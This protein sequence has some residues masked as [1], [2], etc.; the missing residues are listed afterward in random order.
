MLPL[1]RLLLGP[2]ARQTAGTGLGSRQELARSPNSSSEPP[3]ESHRFCPLFLQSILASTTMPRVARSIAQ[4]KSI[5]ASHRAKPMTRQRRRMQAMTVGLI[6]LGRC[7]Y[8][9]IDKQRAECESLRRLGRGQSASSESSPPRQ[10][11]GGF[12]PTT[13]GHNPVIEGAS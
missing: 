1:L 6:Q 2:L 9:D 13:I 8:R 10:I 4:L 5:G 11:E 12:V 3:C 7:E